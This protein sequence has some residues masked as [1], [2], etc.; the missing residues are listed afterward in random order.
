MFDGFEK[1]LNRPPL[2]SQAYQISPLVVVSRNDKAQL[3]FTIGSFEPKPGNG[4][5]VSH[6][7]EM[8]LLPP[9]SLAVKLFERSELL[10]LTIAA[11]PHHGSPRALSYRMEKTHR[12][13]LGIC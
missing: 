2:A 12:A 13:K 6:A 10:Y 8:N 3:P 7:N 1:A 5:W 9:P 4:N 11:H